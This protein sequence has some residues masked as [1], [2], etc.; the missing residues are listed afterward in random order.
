MDKFSMGSDDLISAVNK[1]KDLGGVR[2]EYLIDKGEHKL[3]ELFALGVSLKNWVSSKKGQ[4]VKSIKVDDD[5]YMLCASCIDPSDITT[6]IRSMKGSVHMSGTLQPLEHHVKTIGLP[7]TTFMKTYPTPFPH[8]NRKVIYVNDVTTKYN[9]RNP[10]M[11]NRIADHVI[12]LCNKV[13]KNTLVSFTSYGMMSK[14]KQIVEGKIDK[15][16]YWE[17]SG[18]QKGTMKSLD[19]FRKGRNGVFFIVIGGSVA[20]GIDLPGD[21][22]SFAI[23]VGMPFPPETVES[24]AMSYMFDR[25]YGAGTGWEYVSEVPTIRQMKQVIGRL[26]R[27]ETDRGMAVILDSRASKYAKQLD[28]QLS[29][30]PV[31]D[32]VRFFR[33]S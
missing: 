22:L 27:T 13:E 11:I 15:R 4:F 33:Y 8:E 12:R 3:S 25:K 5:G 17:E 30:D 24:K 29:E 32:A 19:Q 26:I 21:E 14:I 16:T 1:M 31:A 2:T 23:I 6:F 18:H 7:K 28:A 20:E 10:N 9:E